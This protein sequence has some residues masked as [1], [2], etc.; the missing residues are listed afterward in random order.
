MTQASAFVL[1]GHDINAKFFEGAPKDMFCPRCGSCLNRSYYPS[2][3]S[4]QGASRYD[5]GYTQDLQPLFSKSLV[6]VINDQTGTSVAANEIRGSGGYFHLAV[7]ETI[8]FDAQRR[9]TE[10]GPRCGVCGQFEWVAGATPAFLIGDQVPPDGI[11]KTDLEFGDQHGKSPLLVVGRKLKEIIESHA[12]PGIFFN[13]A[14]CT[15]D[16]Y[17]EDKVH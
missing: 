7:P 10:F 13:D 16:K 15:S 1:R 8:Q 17:K 4:V 3:L 9:K 5:F 6:N 11:L 2:T 12:F 14:Y